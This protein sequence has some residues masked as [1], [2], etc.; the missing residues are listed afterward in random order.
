MSCRQ[1]VNRFFDG[2]SEFGGVKKRAATPWFAVN[3]A[4]LVN[5]KDE[6]ATQK[7]R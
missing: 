6:V 1:L 2:G 5:S 7:R 4:R 3:G